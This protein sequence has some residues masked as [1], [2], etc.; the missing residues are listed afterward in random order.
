MSEKEQSIQEFL[1]ERDEEESKKT[2]YYRI[3]FERLL[4]L[5]TI[6]LSQ[7]GTRRSAF[8]GSVDNRDLYSDILNQKRPVTGLFIEELD[9]FMN[10]RNEEG[11]LIKTEDFEIE[12][13]YLNKVTHNFTIKDIDEERTKIFPYEYEVLGNSLLLQEAYRTGKKNPIIN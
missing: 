9:E 5:I 10:N 7:S 11:I 3:N 13:I 6:Y 8:L 12:H 1:K 4:E 2:Y